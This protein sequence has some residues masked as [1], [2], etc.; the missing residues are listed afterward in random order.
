MKKKTDVFS[1]II[2]RAAGS[3]ARIV[4]PEGSDERIILAAEMAAR[5]DLCEL[6]VL[7]DKITLATK[8][9][10]KALKN[11][12]IIDPA[13]ESKKREMYANTLYELRK[14]KG[15]TPEQA[16]EELKDNLVFAM[17]ML[18]SDDADGIVAGAITETADVL[19]PAFQIIKTKPDCSKVSS[20]ML[21]EMPQGSSLG[22][23]GLMVFADPAVIE[24]PTDEELADIAILSSETAKNICD[25][26]PNV[27]MLSYTS[28]S[29]EDNDSELV[30]KVKR[31][32]KIVRR[33]QPYLRVDGE[34]QVDAALDEA[35]CKRKCPSCEVNGKANVLVFPDLQSGNIGYKLV[36]RIAGVRAVGPILQGLNKPV[37]DLSRGTNA[38]EIMLNIAITVL[39]SRTTVKGI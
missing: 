9:S 35:V 5:K 8:F 29:P 32:Y 37:N 38:E 4:L 19:R 31:A 25:I 33:K 13:T 18:K 7:G 28:K 27:A 3:N 17:L 21:M 16:L 22:E 14:H 39:Q 10:R 30:Q 11:I 1:Q 24:N 34:I 12:T 6:I 36:Q 20:V 15:M 26:S 2:E 23:K